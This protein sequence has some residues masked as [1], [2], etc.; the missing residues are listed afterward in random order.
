MS[1]NIAPH[2]GRYFSPK[3]KISILEAK[4]TSKSQRSHRLISEILFCVDA[5]G[6][7]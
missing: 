3:N 2:C 1:Q 5:V 4:L 7:I 6:K